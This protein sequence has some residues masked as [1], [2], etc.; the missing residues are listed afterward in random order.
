MLRLS[1]KII[2]AKPKWLGKVLNDKER[3][4]F[5]FALEVLWSLLQDTAY[6]SWTAFANLLRFGA[7]FSTS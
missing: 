5:I 2:L 3:K 7:V 4:V 6:L 1:R